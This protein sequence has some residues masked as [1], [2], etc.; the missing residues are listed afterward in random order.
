[1]VD[2]RLACHYSVSTSLANA[3]GQLQPSSLRVKSIKQK[4]IDIRAHLAVRVTH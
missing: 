2:F 3:I 1:M 4:A